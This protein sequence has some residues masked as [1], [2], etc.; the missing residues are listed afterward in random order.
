MQPTG[1]PSLAEI[2]RGWDDYQAMLV[3]AIAPLDDAQLGLAAAPQL[4]SARVLASHVVA[5]REWWFHAW[6]GEGGA[7]WDRYAGWDDLEEAA[8]RSAPEL[9]R[10][11][12]ET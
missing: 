8:R 6:M 4:W 1:D 11:L 12:E 5:V 10:G 9:I 7:E 2:Y 3:R